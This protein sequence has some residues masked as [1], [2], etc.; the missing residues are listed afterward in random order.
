VAQAIETL[1][2]QL[3]IANQRTDRAELRAEADRARADV[4]QAALSEERR[5]V[6]E[7]LTERRPWWRKW[8]R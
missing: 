4:L 2:E 3:D 5:R 6:I 8:L 7:I 1:R